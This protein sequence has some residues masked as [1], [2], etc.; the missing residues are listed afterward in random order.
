MRTTILERAWRAFGPAHFVPLSRGVI[1]T[2]AL[3]LAATNLFATATVILL[4]GGPNP[5]LKIASSGYV[6]GDITTNSV[7]NM[8]S[9]IAADLSGNFLFVADRNNNVIRLLEFDINWTSTLLTLS[10]DGLTVI[11]NL[12][13]NP[14]GVAIDSG[15]NLFVLNRGNGSNG[16]VLQFAVDEDLFAT[17]VATNAANLTNAAGLALDFHDNVYVTIKS[18]KVLKITSPGVSNVVATVTNAGANLQGLVVK[19]NGMLAVCDSGRN[20]IYLID[21]TTGVVTTNAG[22]HGPGDFYSTL[23]H[24]PLSIARF[25][26]PSGV[27]EMGDGNL[28]VTDFGNHRV[29]VVT[30]TSV[31]NLYGIRSNDWYSAYPGLGGAG[32]A[33]L[34]VVPDNNYNDV[35]SRQPL[36]LVIAPDG[37]V[38]VTETYWSVIRKATDN[39]KPPLF[40]PLAP[41]NLIATPGYGQVILTW[42]SS[43]S[44]NVT[45]YYIKRALISGGSGGAY[46]NNIIAST[47]STTYTDT[48]VDDGTLYF[49]VVS[50]VSSTVGEGPISSEVSATPMFSPVPVNL[51]A[52]N[53]NFGP[54]ILTWS[55]SAGATSYNIKQATSSGGP[56]TTIGSSTSPTYSDSSALQGTVYYYV[57]SAVNGGGES[58]NS[59]EVSYKPPVQPPPS[60]RI[61]WFDY[62]PDPSFPMYS[63]TVLH[64]FGTYIANNDLNLAIDPTT[65]GVGT[66]YITTNGPA[67]PVSAAFIATNGF[68]PQVTY[69]D[70]V[71]K[72]IPPLQVT[73]EPDLVIQ[74]VNTNAGGYSAVVTAE[75]LYQTGNP[76]IVGVNAAQFQVNDVTTNVTLWYTIDGSVPTNTAVPPSTSIGPIYITNGL[77]R[78]LSLVMDTGSNILFQARAF[79]QGY[80]PSGIASQIFTPANYVPNTICFGFDSGEASSDFVASPGQTFYAPVTLLPLSSN[81]IYS[82]QFNLTVTNAGPNPG[83]AIPQ[84]P[85]Q[86]TFWS[87][88]V[89]PI[90]G[91]NLYEAIPPWMYITNLVNPPLPGQIRTLDGQTA[92][93]S[94]I[95][96]NIA[97]NLLGVGWVERV[98]KTNLYDTTKQDLIAFSMAHDD[99]FLQA[100]GKVILGGFN[101][102]VPQAATNGQTYQI[103][104]GRPSATL[105]G[106]GAPGSSVYIFTPTN[107][108][109]GGGAVNAI[110]N[111]TMGQR[112]YIAGNVYPFGWFNAGDFG[113]TNLQ[114]ADVEQ[115]FEAAIYG[116][117]SPAFQAPG[118]DFF[119][120][121]DSCGG[122]GVYNAGTGYYTYTGPLSVAQQD[123][124]F[125]GNDTTINQIAFGDGTLDVC[126]VY[127][128]YRRSVDPSL[129]WFRR[130]WTN[131]VRVAETVPNVFQ[132]YMVSKTSS[133]VSKIAQKADNTSVT[134]QPKVN[135]VAGDV[136]ATAAQTIRSAGATIP[137]GWQP[138]NSPAATAQ[139]TTAQTTT[140][141][142]IQVPITANIF[143]NYPLRVL[144]LNLSVVPLDGSPALT[145]PVSFSYNPA[146]GSPS[147]ADQQDNGNYSAAWL[148]SGI[149]GLT[150]NASL[151]TLAVT[152]PTNAT[153]SSAYAVHF[154]HASASPNGI[155]SFPKQTTTGLITLSDRS[156]SS[157]NDGIPDSWRL[158]YFGTIYNY[159]S[160]SNADADGDGMNNWQE[161]VAGTDPTDPKSC[162]PLTA[163]QAQSQTRSITWPSVTGKTYIIQRSTLLFPPHWTSVSTNTG[164]GTTM[165]FD[166]ATGGNTYFY[167]VQVQ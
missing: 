10:P 115:V 158:R 162:L 72:Y 55:A 78:T 125:D 127:V 163:A 48:S 165:E 145:T 107:G 152:I 117:N 26:Q 141:Q 70:G 155:A 124:L 39:I 88:L 71:T 121:M 106:I 42:S 33:T 65:T 103:Q 63:I 142:T 116:L 64:P 41:E 3:L 29:K 45:N 32:A 81:V 58:T 67:Q 24:D 68:T 135:F 104:I 38:Y 7:Y 100:N 51:T 128:T 31:T 97:D 30:G 134:N 156:G 132:P 131:G 136:L 53:H 6:N 86:F 101:F 120:A 157:Y 148:N 122:F 151:G 69:Q 123:A 161:Y 79:R 118:S 61:G 37:S 105:D 40:P 73:I 146:L 166:D 12:F 44:P 167:R 143:G 114:N 35:Q 126:D 113:N 23:N 109:L 52:T 147:M 66:L 139:T 94:L 76:N 144:M 91:A 56:Y 57:V 2:A 164:T 43:A 8:P 34:V 27:A 17:L 153:S 89:K 84:I 59:L 90:S 92:F 47:A 149:S 16:Y 82:L 13:N 20:G 111:V 87:M 25:S 93:V 54:V 112:K 74:A 21:P 137:H 49:Y 98:G 85:E 46:T 138:G 102:Q 11:T 119:D 99:L 9:G 80:S 62:E 159:L 5:P 14:V 130:Y 129:T 36:G 50:A 154:D 18:N 96:T 60:P 19:Y 4:S 28:I 108:S 83:P 133:V 77:P 95:T 140:A 160:V 1:V 15:Y 22:F 150:G 75:I 110:K